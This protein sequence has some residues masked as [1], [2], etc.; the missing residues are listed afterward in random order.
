MSGQLKPGEVFTQPVARGQ[1]PNQGRD[2]QFVPLVE[3]VS[4]RVLRPQQKAGENKLDVRN[5]G[6]TITV[7]ENDPVMRRLPAT[8]GEMGYTVQ[9][10]PIPPKPG[11][12]SA[13]VAG[14]GTNISRMTRICCLPVKRACL[15]KRTP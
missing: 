15:I 1:V 5:L 12:E 13:L 6:E 2:T 4:K 3:D 10:K 14:K 9:G 11:K 8:K 7:G